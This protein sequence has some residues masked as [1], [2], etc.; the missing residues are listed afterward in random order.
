MVN[1]VLAEK[2]PRIVVKK[3]LVS[4]IPTSSLGQNPAVSRDV[5]EK[6]RPFEKRLWV[7]NED[8]GRPV[9]FIH[10]GVV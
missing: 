2:S 10:S 1:V 4:L 3:V 9:E 5:R 6:A 7:G 8:A